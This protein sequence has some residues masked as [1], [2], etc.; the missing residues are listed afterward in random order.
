[1]RYDLLLKLI[2][3]EAITG[4]LRVLELPAAVDY[5]TVEFPKRSKALPDLVVRLTDGR[6]LHIE[7]QSKN[8]PRIAWR[9]L[10]YWQLISEQWPGLEVVQVV[11]YLGDGPLTMTSDITLGDMR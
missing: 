3:Q 1:M 11:I 9:C 6:I 4:L 2:F 7:F 10:E 5:L 8:D